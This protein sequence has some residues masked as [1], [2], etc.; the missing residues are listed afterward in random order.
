MPAP[1]ATEAATSP[2]TRV[3]AAKRAA[4][5]PRTDS[6]ENA[7]NT[8]FPFEQDPLTW[9]VRSHQQNQKPRELC[10]AS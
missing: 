3:V 1:T 9:G 2:D 7:A 6:A 4:P 5:R 8:K 10:P